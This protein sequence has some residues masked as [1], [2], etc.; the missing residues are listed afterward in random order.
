MSK[1]LYITDTQDFFDDFV[2]VLDNTTINLLKEIQ[3]LNQK[4]PTETHQVIVPIQT[5]LV[6]QR[7]GKFEPETI[8]LLTRTEFESLE[9][10]Y[11]SDSTL[12]AWKK[13]FTINSVTDLLTNIL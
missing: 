2:V 1:Y 7:L 10:E 9:T 12:K 8:N 5:Y 13:Y 6:R 11:P 3:E 4:F